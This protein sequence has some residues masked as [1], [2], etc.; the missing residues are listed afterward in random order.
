MLETKP[1]AGEKHY[2]AAALAS[3]L[4]TRPEKDIASGGHAIGTLTAS[5]WRL[6]TSRD[7][8]ETVLKAVNLGGDT[9]TTG[10][11]AGGIGRRLLRSGERASAV[12]HSDGTSTGFG[13]PVR[14]IP[15]SRGAE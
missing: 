13:V 15:T 5:L 1:L 6:L 11:A 12:A 14:E 7:Y 8:T 2:F 3:H 10:V 4:A 9:D